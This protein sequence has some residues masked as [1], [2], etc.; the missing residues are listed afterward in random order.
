MSIVQGTV[1]AVPKQERYWAC[2][3]IVSGCI[4]GSPYKIFE[5]HDR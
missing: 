4:H 2:K 1:V 3:D 5:N